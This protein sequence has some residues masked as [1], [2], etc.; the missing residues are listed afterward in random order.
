[1]LR[2]VAFG[3]TMSFA[4]SLAA[5]GAFL[6]SRAILR[7]DAWWNPGVGWLAVL[8]STVAIVVA[9]TTLVVRAIDRAD[10]ARFLRTI[11]RP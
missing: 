9:V 8:A 2:A 10:R 7:P 11:R 4:F 1:M 6:L 3:L 5:A